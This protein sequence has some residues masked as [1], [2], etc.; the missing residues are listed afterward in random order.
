MNPAWF[1]HCHHL[2]TQRAKHTGPSP[3]STP[4]LSRYDSEFE[5]NQKQ[6]LM[7]SVWGLDTRVLSKWTPRAWGGLQGS[8]ASGWHRLP[9]RLSLPA[10]LGSSDNSVDV[11]IPRPVSCLLPLNRPSSHLCFES[12]R[13]AISSAELPGGLTCGT[14]RAWGLKE[15]SNAAGGGREAQ[16]LSV[17]PSVDRAHGSLHPAAVSTPKMSIRLQ[18]GCGCP[19]TSP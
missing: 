13:V 12:L 18:G 16:L 1:P 15:Q 9:H 4:K 8:W 11:G 17:T 19:I 2:D 3:T 6:R 7:T 14:R 5:Q 10:R